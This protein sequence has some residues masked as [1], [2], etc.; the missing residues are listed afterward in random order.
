MHSKTISPLEALRIVTEKCSGPE[1][2]SMPVETAAG[3]FL[4]EAVE[5]DLFP[6]HRGD[7]RPHS[8]RCSWRPPGNL[9]LVLAIL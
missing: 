4:E 5:I 8:S 2:I 6:Y 1:A 9:G 3:V 7:G